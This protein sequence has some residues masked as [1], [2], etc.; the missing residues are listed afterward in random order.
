MKKLNNFYD[1]IYKCSKCGL[2]QDVCPVFKITKNEASLSRGK[3]LMLLSYL[4]GKIPLSKTLKKYLDMCTSCGACSNFCPSNIDANKIF[5]L[6][7]FE[8]KKKSFL[9]IFNFF[10]KFFKFFKNLFT[11]KRKPKYF[12]NAQTV[13]YFEGCFVKCVNSKTKK[14]TLSVLEKLKINVVQPNFECCGIVAQ[15]LGDKKMFEYQ[16]EK[17][18]DILKNIQADYIIFDCASCLDVVKNY[19]KFFEI[20][21]FDNI[22]NKCVSILEFLEIKNVKFSSNNNTQITYHKPCHLEYDAQKI[23]NNIENVDYIQMHD[24]DKCCGFAGEF[25]IKNNKIAESMFKNKVNNINNTPCN[26]VLTFC[27][28]CELGLMMAKKYTK[29]KF[30][31][32][33]I[34]EFL[35]D[36][37]IIS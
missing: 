22:K 1:E 35:N 28:S 17:N 11:K 14:A 21:D 36:L 18:I 37:K 15:S 26:T 33:N 31:I 5:T 3:F 4:D 9:N 27:P 34:I 16:F 32:L 6:A 8:F 19:D 10:I 13:V 25:A 7:K 30:K 20:D 2:C 23:L 12:E 24:F 29:K